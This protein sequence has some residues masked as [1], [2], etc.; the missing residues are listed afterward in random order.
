[1]KIVA[2]RERK[3]PSYRLNAEE[4]GHFLRLLIS[5][6]DSENDGDEEDNFRDKLHFSFSITKKK[7]EIQFENVDEVIEYCNGIH[8]PRITK[9][10]LYISKGLRDKRISVYGGLFSTSSTI[11]ATSESVEWS[12]GVLEAASD[13][14][15]NHRTWYWWFSYIPFSLGALSFGAT[16]TYASL[17]KLSP[18]V[19]ASFA[20]L[21][22]VS[23][24]FTFFE[25][26][27]FPGALIETKT[28]ESFI[29]RYASELSVIIS[30]ASLIVALIALLLGLPN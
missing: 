12:I 14:I 11:K 4:L 27:L 13:F 19:S 2:E 10:S 9:F 17:Q 5:K 8:N 16:G 21:A 7:D 24:F 1:M 6:F 23:L 3:L 29:K 20:G 22:F 15:D 25:E 26:S 28:K 18:W 30:L